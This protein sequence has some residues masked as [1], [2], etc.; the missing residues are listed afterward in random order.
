RQQQGSQRDPSHRPR[1]LPQQSL[2]QQTPAP[3]LPWSP[4]RGLAIL[5]SRLSGNPTGD[6]PPPP[7]P[8]PGDDVILAPTLRFG[9]GTGRT[10]GIMRRLLGPQSSMPRQAPLRPRAWAGT[11]DGSILI[12][13]T[14]TAANAFGAN[15][16]SLRTISTVDGAP[17]DEQMNR[18]PMLVRP[19]SVAGVCDSSRGVI[20]L[21]ASMRWYLNSF[22]RAPAPALEE[23]GSTAAS[24]S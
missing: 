16:T 19:G 12:G 3:H 18:R 6:P 10:M 2:R 13:G 4:L 8:P 1:L 7:P 15:G 23:P 21:R 14:A 24:S 22:R 20:G 9:S 11:G 17:T 5:A